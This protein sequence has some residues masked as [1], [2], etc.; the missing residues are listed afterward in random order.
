MD[1]FFGV[2]YHSHL[3][4]KGWNGCL[5]KRRFPKHSIHNIENSPFRTKF[6]KDVEEFAGNIGIGCIS[7]SEAQPLLVNSHLGSF[8]ITTVGR[9]NNLDELRTLCFEQGKTHF[10]E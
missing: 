2:D 10:L 7:D 6:D 3:G 1:L 5:R 8:A 9:I 4:T